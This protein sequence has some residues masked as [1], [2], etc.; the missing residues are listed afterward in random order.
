MFDKLVPGR[1]WLCAPY[2]E[3][4]FGMVKSTQN[5]KMKRVFS[6]SEF[7]GVAAFANIMLGKWKVAFSHVL[8]LPQFA[9]VM[10]KNAILSKDAAGR[11]QYF[12]RTPTFRFSP[13]LGLKQSSKENQ[14][15]MCF[16]IFFLT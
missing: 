8:Y 6:K 2:F 11:T 10:C 7:I 13:P 5:L 4:V 3:R 12:E 14:I 9:E 16:R 15:N 1:I